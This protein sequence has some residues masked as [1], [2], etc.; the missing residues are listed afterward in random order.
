MFFRMA[1]RAAI[2]DIDHGNTRQAA[3]PELRIAVRHRN[4]PG[5]FRLQGADAP[6]NPPPSAALPYTPNVMEARFAPRRRRD[7]GGQKTMTLRGEGIAAEFRTLVENYI[8]RRFGGAKSA[9]GVSV[10]TAPQSGFLRCRDAGLMEVG[11]APDL[12]GSTARVWIGAP[13]ETNS[14]SLGR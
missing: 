8:E 5:C 12:D 11:S 1:Q 2:A 3:P 13:H 9:D 14:T 10:G 4:F 7:A 6:F